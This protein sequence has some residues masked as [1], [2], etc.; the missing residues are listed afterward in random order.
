M[1]PTPPMAFRVATPHLRNPCGETSTTGL[2]EGLAGGEGIWQQAWIK[3]ALW[4]SSAV[5]NKILTDFSKPIRK[6][7]N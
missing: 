6:D 3:A 7:L 2:L 4:L 5:S 1:G